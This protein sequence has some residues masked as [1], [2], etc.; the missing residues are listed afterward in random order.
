MSHS[1]SPPPD[2]VHVPSWEEAL[3]IARKRLGDWQP[4]LEK[5]N[6]WDQRLV[7]EAKT[8]INEKIEQNNPDNYAAGA[9][10]YDGSDGT[11]VAGGSSFA[12]NVLEE[13]FVAD[14]AGMSFNLATDVASRNALLGAYQSA[15]KT[16]GNTNMMHFAVSTAAAIA[17]DPRDIR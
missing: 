6:M 16:F 3:V 14:F 2:T 11:A 1:S 12:F 4:E 13:H 10:G 7:A 9:A 5:Q 17:R 8:I 15:V